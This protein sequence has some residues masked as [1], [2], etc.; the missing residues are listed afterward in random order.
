MCHLDLFLHFIPS[1]PHC[2]NQQ[3]VKPEQTWSP[4]WLVYLSRDFQLQ[5]S[6]LCYCACLLSCVWHFEVTPLVLKLLSELDSSGGLV[7]T[8]WRATALRVCDSGGLQWGSKNFISSQFPRLHFEKY[9]TRLLL[10]FVLGIP[11]SN[12]HFPFIHMNSSISHS[13]S[14]LIGLSSDNHIISMTFRYTMAFYFKSTHTSWFCGPGV[15][16]CKMFCS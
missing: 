7:N 16:P 11:A 10:S 6:P 15:H 13:V 1:G 5:K 3:W 12:L 14:L 2:S 9:C 4:S 8:D